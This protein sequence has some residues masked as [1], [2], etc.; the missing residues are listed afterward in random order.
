MCE[1]ESTVLDIVLVW[2]MFFASLWYSGALRVFAPNLGKIER[3]S[4]E[5]NWVRQ[6]ILQIC[7]TFALV[8]NVA[9]SKN[10]NKKNKDLTLLLRLYH[11]I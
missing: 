9:Q 8:R 6:H 3:G 5:Q 7:K 4:R 2:V 11:Y 1:R 10:K